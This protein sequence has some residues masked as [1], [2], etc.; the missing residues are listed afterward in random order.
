MLDSALPLLLFLLFL[1]GSTILI[2]AMGYLSRDE[3]LMQWDA[4]AA[5]EAS[6][7]GFFADSLPTLTIGKG[8]DDALRT[9]VEG[10]VE[11]ERRLADAFVAEPT[12]ERLYGRPGG[13]LSA[14]S[15]LDRAERFL[16]EERSLAEGFVSDPSL[17]RL[18]GHLGAGPI[19]A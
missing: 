12:V 14:E 11:A 4:T 6:G 3:S 15:F 18:Y 16:R 17:H 10:R 7:S 8:F 5:P 9:A 1:F 2:L 19:Q 13:L